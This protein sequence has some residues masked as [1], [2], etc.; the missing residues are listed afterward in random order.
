MAI[1][2][3]DLYSSLWASCDELRGGMDASLYKDYVLVLLFM[4][5]VSDKYAGQKDALLDV[6]KGGSFS[7]MVALKGDKKIGD[8]LNK[9]ITKLAEADIRKA[10]IQRG[11]IKGIISLPAAVQSELDRVSQTLTGRIRQLSDRYATPLPQITEEVA[12][13][14]AKVEGHLKKMRFKL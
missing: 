13:L 1:K 5:Y 6:P 8:K 12:M 2:K 7:D 3:S 4:K 9:I 10:I 14:S 11:F